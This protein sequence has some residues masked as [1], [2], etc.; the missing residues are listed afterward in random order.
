[1]RTEN[2][3]SVKP[4]H[5]LVFDSGVGGLSIAQAIKQMIP[6]CR[7]SYASDNAYFPY[8]TK[9]EAQLIDRVEH[10]L[11]TIQQEVSADIIVV[12]CNT[13]STLV[14]PKIREHFTLPII[15]VVPAIKPAAE[16]SSNKVIGLLATPGTVK[17]SY[18]E[19]LINDFANHC[20]VISV[21]SSELV[22]LAEKKLQGETISLPELQQLMSPFNDTTNHKTP[23]TIVL[24][25]THFPLL[26]EELKTVLPHISHWVDSGEA[27]ARRAIFWIDKLKL[28]KQE[29]PATSTNNGLSIFTKKTRE[30]EL[31]RPALDKLNLT[32]I[33]YMEIN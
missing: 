2:V 17:R 7:L 30:T 16:I 6:S 18:T 33:Q 26:K 1:M 25:C 13:A 14:L 11:T 10:V 19:G 32:R 4:A 20:N 12:A 15:G 5:I 22:I 23:D 9:N 27:I 3:I 24:A 28:P 21:G 8:G 31:I 29:S